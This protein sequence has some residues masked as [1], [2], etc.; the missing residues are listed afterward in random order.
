MLKRILIAALALGVTV[1]AEAGTTW[2]KKVDSAQKAAKKNKQLIFVDLFA[3]WCG[4]CH[5]MEREVF[6]TEAFQKATDDMVL[7]RLDTEDNGEGSQFARDIGVTSLPTFVVLT[8]DLTIAA[9][10]KG[11]AP[12]KDFVSTMASVLK[13]YD[14]FRKNVANDAKLD[15][16]KRLE[17]YKEL[18]ARRAYATAEGKLVKL[19]LDKAT[20]VA[21][22][23][24]GYYLL[25]LSQASQKKFDLATRTVDNFLKLQPKGTLS[26]QVHFMKAQI[27]LEQKQLKPALAELKR[28]KASHPKSELVA[29][30]N[31]LIPQIEKEIST[32]KAQ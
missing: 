3:D 30:V 23:D 14:E 1:G 19:V 24:E 22:R 31:Q 6:P 27:L 28:F 15:P 13:Q 25:V 5:R 26:E 8:D 29:N 2:H 21:I 18:I 20:P 11:Y 7:L 12:A 9:V 16:K 17:L 4:W 10:I 32:A